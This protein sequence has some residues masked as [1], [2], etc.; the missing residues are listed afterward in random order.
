MAVASLL[1]TYR[2]DPVGVRDPASLS[3]QYFFRDAEMTL[4]ASDGRAALT[5]SAGAATRAQEGSALKLEDVLVRLTDPPWSIRADFAEL[6]HEDAE[7]SVEGDVRLDLGQTG[8]WT[9]RARRARVGKDGA[10]VTLN[11]DFDI[12]GPQGNGGGSAIR[13][14]HIILEPAGMKART[15]RPVRVRLGQYEFEAIGLNARI[16]EQAITL[17]SDVRSIIEP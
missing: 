15:D 7:I 10:T 5:I 4:T 13:G 8:E 17:E 3:R 1:L 11:D 16:G 9:A 6:P 2:T 14:D 12:R